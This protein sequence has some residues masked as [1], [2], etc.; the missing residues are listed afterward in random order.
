MYFEEDKYIIYAYI[1]ST[2]WDWVGCS[3]TQ[4]SFLKC[5]KSAS[6]LP[7]IRKKLYCSLYERIFLSSWHFPASKHFHTFL[8]ISNIQTVWWV[9]DKCISSGQKWKWLFELAIM[10]YLQIATREM[11]IKGHGISSFMKYVGL[12]NRLPS[13]NPKIFPILGLGF[14]EDYLQWKGA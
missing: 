7:Q 14:E 11:S 3:C 5:H 13:K 6:K 1:S 2:V 9:A 4:S 8:L 12:Q 10:L